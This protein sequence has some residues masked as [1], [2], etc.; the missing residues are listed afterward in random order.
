M[1]RGS[2]SETLL[3]L[4][5]SL[6]LSLSLFPYFLSAFICDLNREQRE[7]R[8]L[9]QIHGFTD[10][11]DVFLA[12]PFFFFLRRERAERWRT[13]AAF[14]NLSVDFQANVKRDSVNYGE[15]RWSQSE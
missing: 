2:E 11:F 14:M 9:V 5:L 13:T 7:K 12:F 6:S 1:A 3:F 4:S 8:S 15:S 10:F